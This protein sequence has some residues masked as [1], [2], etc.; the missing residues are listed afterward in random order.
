MDALVDGAITGLAI[1]VVAVICIGAFV[2]WACTYD[3][4]TFGIDEPL[5]EHEP[6]DRG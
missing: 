2:W 5:L 3:D 6:A 1:W 4:T